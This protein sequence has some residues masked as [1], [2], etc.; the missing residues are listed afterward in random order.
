MIE[1][2]AEKYSDSVPHYQLVKYDYVAVPLYKIVLNITLLRNKDMG[3]IEEFV[4][5]LL[6]ANILKADQIS[7]FLG[8]EVF[9][10]N[11][12]LANLVKFDLV[13]PPISTNFK[14]TDKGRE[15]LRLS[16][17]IQPQEI[18]Y[19]F[20][21]DGMTGE[22]HL[23]RKTL[24]AKD[25][26]F[27][28]IHP[29]KTDID[30]P[31]VD[32]LDFQ[33][34]SRLMK[35]HLKETLDS[36]YDGD[37]IS[38]NS[39][40]KCYTEYKKK[41]LLVFKHIDDPDSI[42][43]RVFD[44]LDRD[45]KYEPIILWMEQMGIR[46]IPTD[47]KNFIDETSEA[48]TSYV[49]IEVVESAKENKKKQGHFKTIEESLTRRI[50][51][52]QKFK[53]QAHLSHEEKLTATL[54]IKQLRKQLDEVKQQ[55]ASNNRLLETYNHRPLLEK[56]L[57]EAKQL[58]VIVSP[59]IRFGAFD[60]ELQNLIRIAL[61]RNVTILI[62]YGIGRYDV[63]ND[64]AEKILRDMQ[65]KKYGKNL[66]LVKLDNTHEKLLL[67]DGKYV[68]ITSFNWLSFKGD[69]NRGFRQETGIYTED[70]N[71]ISSLIDS[72]SKRMNIEI[73]RY[74]SSSTSKR[75]V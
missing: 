28:D 30:V 8:L 39:I 66:I 70:E 52:Q 5:K 46:Q 49:P 29:L 34:L 10:I 3:V 37:L 63:E 36:S 35:K 42:D 53:E 12:A 31:K 45:F 75:H 14:I 26:K 74:L 25:V 11:D 62:G 61:Q 51:E 4:L 55:K 43:I 13:H 18:A 65:Q 9:L 20:L 23:D 16:R 41:I 38:I 2:L 72:L 50:D 15:A 22:Y 64:K 67:V 56:S 40:Q 44:G 27:H 48:I 21:I 59:W 17:L 54:E 47:K 1:R 69:P 19:T 71:T 24:K 7:N 60:N 73:R 68:V 32:K 33:E 58:I 57:K 6:D